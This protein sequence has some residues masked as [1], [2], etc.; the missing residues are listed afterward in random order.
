MKNKRKIKMV[1]KKKIMIVLM[2]K[3][4]QVEG[5]GHAPG[6]LN[7]KVKNKRKIKGD[8]YTEIIGMKIH[9]QEIEIKNITDQETGETPSLTLKKRTGLLILL[10]EEYLMID[11]TLPPEGKN[12]LHQIMINAMIGRTGATMT[13]PKDEKIE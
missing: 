8:R 12:M 13:I 1:I 6:L 9:D 7:E 10:T 4:L 3:M 11:I 5:P 2:I